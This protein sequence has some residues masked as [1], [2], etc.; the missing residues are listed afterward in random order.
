MSFL[1]GSIDDY[2]FSKENMDEGEVGGIKWVPVSDADSVQWA[3]DHDV[4]IQK[5]IQKFGGRMYGDNT[6]YSNASQMIDKAISM[7]QNGEDE[8]YIISFLNKIK[9]NL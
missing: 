4:L 7:V 6:K 3:F 9:Q 2:Q 8:E 1:N 5:L